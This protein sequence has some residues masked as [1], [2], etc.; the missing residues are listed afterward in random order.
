MTL[1]KAHEI[2]RA[3]KPKKLIEQA[4][5]RIKKFIDAKA[6]LKKERM[7]RHIRNSGKAMFHKQNKKR[8]EIYLG[9]NPVKKKRFKKTA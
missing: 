8:N 3:D 7:E 9:Y 4:K 2:V 5:A 1:S 6:R